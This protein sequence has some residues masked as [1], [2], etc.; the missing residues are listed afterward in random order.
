MERSYLPDLSA[1]IKIGATGMDAILQNMRI[2]I[3]TFAYS[4]PLDR[5]FANTGRMIDSPA[6]VRTARLAAQLVNALEKYEPRIKVR[7]V[8][9][10]YNDR[11]EQLQQGHII[12]KIFYRLKDGVAL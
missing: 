2:I 12:P 7:K 11:A 5:A 4:V 3:L 1:P 9:F 10:V 8:E 6:P